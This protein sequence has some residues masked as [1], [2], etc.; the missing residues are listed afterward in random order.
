MNDN[1]AKPELPIHMILGASDYA[2][3]KVAE[4]PKRG[5]PGEP[6]AKLTRFGWVIMSPGNEI[7]S[8][9]LVLS[10]NSIDDYEKFAISVY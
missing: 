10:R 1:D 3:I 6:V 7:N 5:S 8:N 2:R 9:N 4:M